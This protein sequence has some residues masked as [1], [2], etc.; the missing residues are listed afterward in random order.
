MWPDV[1]QFRMVTTATISMKR[2]LGSRLLINQ[3]CMLQKLAT[4]RS[5]SN[6]ARLLTLSLDGNQNKGSRIFMPDKP[7]SNL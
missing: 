2:R 1:E 5:R 7:A 6:D 3:R 4:V